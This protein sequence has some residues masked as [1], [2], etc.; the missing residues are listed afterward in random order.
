[1]VGANIRRLR[2]ARGWSQE[3]LASLAGLHWTYI[4]SVERGERNVSVD[5]ICRLAAA[6]N[7]EA[8]ALFAPN[9]A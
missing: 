8:A 4:G 2:K 5:N 1:M 9:P 7:V 6:L 3:T